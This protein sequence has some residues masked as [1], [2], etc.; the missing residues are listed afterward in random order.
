MPQY[1]FALRSWE[2]RLNYSS[3]IRQPGHAELTKDYSNIL[4]RS[5]KY[6]IMNHFNLTCVMH[7]IS[8]HRA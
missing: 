1:T 2:V 4:L 7:V 6:H 3:E 5:I 8:S